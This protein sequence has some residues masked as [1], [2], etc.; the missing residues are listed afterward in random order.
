M[1]D[2]KKLEDMNKNIEY[3]ESSLKQKYLKN[4]QN[5]IEL[6][7]LMSS[8]IN[9]YYAILKNLESFININSI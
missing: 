4:K 1:N 5:S 3:I 6:N 9:H 7:D 8:T 2:T